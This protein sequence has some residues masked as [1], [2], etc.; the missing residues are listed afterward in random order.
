MTS[1]NYDY[2]STYICVHLCFYYALPQL[3]RVSIPVIDVDKVYI[4]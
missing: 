2:V 3:I 1:M 4:L